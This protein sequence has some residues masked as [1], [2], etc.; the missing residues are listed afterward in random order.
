MVLGPS[1]CRNGAVGISRVMLCETYYSHV[2]HVDRSDLLTLF[3]LVPLSL[4]YETHDE[5]KMVSKKN[6]FPLNRFPLDSQSSYEYLIH[7]Q[8]EDSCAH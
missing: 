8:G 2:V 7:Y 5:Y 1:P 6:H 4:G 3:L